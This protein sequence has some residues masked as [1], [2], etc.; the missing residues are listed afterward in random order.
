MAKK[1][2][3]IQ[4]S[5]YILVPFITSGAALIWVL[6]TDQVI[7]YINASKASSWVFLAWNTAVIIITYLMSLLITWLMR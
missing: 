2:Y 4:I 5:L 1:K 6:L 7:N 3:Q